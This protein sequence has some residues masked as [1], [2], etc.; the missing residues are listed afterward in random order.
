MNNIR[1][2]KEFTFDCAHALYNYNG[3]CRNIH[4][5]TYKLLVTVKGTIDEDESS[6]SYGMIIDFSVLKKLV[7]KYIVDVYDHSLVVNEKLK[8]PVEFT[9]YQDKGKY[10]EFD[11]QA[12]CENMVIKFASILKGILPKSCSLFS[13]KL[14]ETPTSYAE[15]YASDNEL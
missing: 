14:Y 2:T 4:G 8:F 15:W 5:H 3:L 11:G 10:I 7:K 12:T 9:A 1:V 13:V 6:P